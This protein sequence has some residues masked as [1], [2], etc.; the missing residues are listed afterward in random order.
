MWGDFQTLFKQ[1]KLPTRQKILC[2]QVKIYTNDIKLYVKDINISVN[3][4]IPSFKNDWSLR[5]AV[6]KNAR[7]EN[8]IFKKQKIQLVLFLG[9]LPQK[10]KVKNG[11][12]VCSFYLTKWRAKFQCLACIFQNIQIQLHLV[13]INSLQR[14]T[15]P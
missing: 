10:L 12:F 1:A 14:I 8:G 3:L 4:Q 11:L 15:C 6:V 2:F 5:S 9:S 13:C 7:A